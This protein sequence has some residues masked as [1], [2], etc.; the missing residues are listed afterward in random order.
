[1]GPATEAALR[2]WHVAADLVPPQATAEALVAAFPAPRSGDGGVLLPQAA[3]ARPT[4]AEGLRAAGW[5]VTTVDAYAT[6]PVRPPPEALAGARAADA[7]AF[8]SPS[9]VG[10]WLAAAGPDGVP[11]VVACIGPTTTAAA[12]RHGLRVDVEA[13]AQTAD[14][15]VDA[16]VS[17]LRTRGA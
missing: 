13:V 15:L 5:E 4:L 17:F 3:E 11:P 14:G 16:L 12:R 10:S 2:R 9:A 6:A 7:I 8:A 1:V